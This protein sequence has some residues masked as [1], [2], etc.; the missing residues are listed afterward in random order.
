MEAVSVRASS[1]TN[2]IMF[3][4]NENQNTGRRQEDESLCPAMPVATQLGD[5]RHLSAPSFEGWYSNNSIASCEV[6]VT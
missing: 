3:N 2:N 5:L 4:R 1:K 6:P